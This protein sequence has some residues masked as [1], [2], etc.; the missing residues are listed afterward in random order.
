MKNI[1]HF[2]M[3]E[4]FRQSLI[5]THRFYLVQAKLKLL[6]QFNNIESEA[7]EACESWLENNKSK[8]DPDRHDAGDFYERANDAG[9]EFYQL[10]SD[11]RDQ[12]WLSVVAGMYHEWDKQLRKWI[13][14]EVKHWHRGENVN[15]RIW[16][17]TFGDIVDF[18]ES[19]GWGIRNTNYFQ[20]LMACNLIVNVYKHGDGVAFE[21]LKASVPEFLPAIDPLWDEIG[22]RDYSY[23][24]VSESQL[25]RLSQAILGFW[26]DV[27]PQIIASEDISVPSWFEKALKKDNDMNGRKS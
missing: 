25:E 12:T 4:P 6:S 15:S 23:L 16:M 5:E 8:F 27:P 18:L 24:K 1:V 10:L 17:V 21:K 19:F 14:D 2:Q 22:Y 13:S 9:I 11:M 20:D 7:D 26:E 3:W